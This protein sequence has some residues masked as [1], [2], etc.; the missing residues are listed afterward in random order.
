MV[1]KPQEIIQWLFSRDRDKM[2]EIK[3]YRE[4]RSLTAN[5]YA[6]KLITEIA[7]VL[8][9]SKDECYVIMLKRYGQRAAVTLNADVDPSLYFDY[10]EPLKDGF[11]KGKR[12][13][14]YMVYAGSSTYNTREMAILID[15]IIQEAQALDIETL[16]PD[17]VNR[18]K[19]MWANE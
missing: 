2:F 16:P 9:I 13:R 15:G 12:F 17:E 6:W 8:R 4:K 3:E 5:A 19:E 10:Y 18:L 1:G 7:N 14:G 11:A